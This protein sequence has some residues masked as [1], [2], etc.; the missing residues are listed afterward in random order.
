MTIPMRNKNNCD[1]SY[2]G[3]KNAF[4]L[5]VQIARGREGLDINSTNAPSSQMEE[6]PDAVVSTYCCCTCSIF[7]CYFIFIF[8]T[9]LSSFFHF[10]ISIFYFYGLNRYIVTWDCFSFFYYC[11]KFVYYYFYLSL[12]LTHFISLSLSLS[13]GSLWRRY[14]RSMC[15]LSISG[16][17]SCGRQ[18]ETCSKLYW[19]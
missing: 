4:R 8:S 14:I 9:F 15:L 16:L 5:S 7:L 12:T 11:S 3:L 2:A 13:L 1:F 19:R 10:F 18:T 17:L 6:A